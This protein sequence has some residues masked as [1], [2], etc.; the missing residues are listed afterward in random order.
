M[1]ILLE[2][3]MKFQDSLVL[4]MLSYLMSL[5]TFLWVSFWYWFS[6]WAYIDWGT[7]KITNH[8][9][10]SNPDSKTIEAM[11]Q[12]PLTSVLSSL[13]SFLV[14]S[15]HHARFL[16]SVHQYFIPLSKVLSRDET[17]TSLYVRNILKI[18][19]KYCH[20]IYIA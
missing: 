5:Y 9:S 11:K 18:S 10:C 15:N 13:Q 16:P 7:T 8:L 19:R 12:K 14:L 3:F 17:E 1:T 4:S 20:P 2:H 6:S